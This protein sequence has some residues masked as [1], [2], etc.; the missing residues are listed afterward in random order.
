MKRGMIKTVIVFI[1]LMMAGCAN[2]QHVY[3][4]DGKCISCWNNP[5]TGK[6]LNHDGKT[7]QASVS[8]SKVDNTQTQ[9]TS[10]PHSELPFTEYKVG[11]VA[12]INVDLAFLTLKKEF[13]YYTE[14]E[15]RQKWGSLANTKIQTFEYAYDA[16]PAVYYH[17]RSDRQHNGT[18][19]VID[20]LIEKQSSTSSKVTLTYW[21]NNP[22][23]DASSFGESLKARAKKALE[24]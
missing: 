3:S 4:S 10:D 18:Q 12:P 24:K 6:P 21:L 14:Q 8:E 9:K 19:V 16:T 22:A 15:I 23:I 17:M 11:F 20:S 7:E 2:N 5:I 1:G 13:N